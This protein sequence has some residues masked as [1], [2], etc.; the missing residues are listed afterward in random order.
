MTLEEVVGR[1]ALDRLHDTARRQM[2]RDA[3]QQVDVVRPDVALQDLDVLR[4]TDLSNQI[5]QPY[6]PPKH[7]LAILRDE[8]E[9]VMQ[10]IHTMTR[11]RKSSKLRHPEL[12]AST[13]VVTPVRK[14]NSSGSTLLSPAHSSLMPVVAKT[15]TCTSMRP[16]VT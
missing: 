11:L 16:G 4:P 3:Q 7:R 1:L 9:M 12:P 10:C 8:Y 14:L 15:W 6:V 13:I 5:A 2:R